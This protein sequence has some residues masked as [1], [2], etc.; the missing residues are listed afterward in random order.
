MADEEHVGTVLLDAIKANATRA[1][2]A[3]EGASS[4]PPTGFA[5]TTRALAEAA[6]LLGL[7]ARP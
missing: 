2:E 4:S 1:K 7:K 5:E 6:H 3:A